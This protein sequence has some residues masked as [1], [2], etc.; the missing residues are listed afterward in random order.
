MTSGLQ[1]SASFESA[2][3]TRAPGTESE[4][5]TRNRA[6]WEDWAP[7]HL[8]A[9]RR[10]WSRD[11]LNWGLWAT[12]ET[13]LMLLRDV[14][15]GQDVIELGCGAGE[16]SA[17][18]SD[19]GLRP[20][21]IDISPKQVQ[22][23][24]N[25]QSQFGL[26]FPVLCANAEEVPYEDASFDLAISEYGANLWCDPRNWLT[27]A[28]RLLRPGGRVLFFANAPMLKVCTPPSGGLAE[29]RLAREYFAPPELEFGRDGPVEF[30]PTHGDWVRHLRATG[31]VLDELIEVRPDK[32]AQA[33][34]PL[35]SVDWARRWPSE[36]I[37]IAHKSA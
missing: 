36:E 11:E 15:V 31:F 21:A 20:V 12:P 24:R 13:R 22:N 6:A 23:V 17:Y 5:I 29:E 8:A 14:E 16:I 34:F 30:H 32:D 3:G 18:L 2:P 27:E 19:H 1:G 35:A 25:L 10:A 7:A 26:D 28:S 9:G 4:Y 33:R 37:W